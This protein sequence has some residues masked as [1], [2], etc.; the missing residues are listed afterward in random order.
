MLTVFLVVFVDLLG[1]GIVLPLAPRYARDY[2]VGWS[3]NAQ[4]LVIGAIYSSFSLMQF[5]FSPVLGRVSDRVGRRPVLF[6]S[7]L[8]SVVFY[9]L[10]AVASSLPTGQGTLALVLLL[11]SRVG[12]GIAGASVSTASAVIADCTTRQTRARGMGLIGAAFGIGFTFGPLIAYLGLE[13]FQAAHWGPGA[14][15]AGLSAAALLLA[16]L[17][18]PETRRPGGPAGAKEYFSLRRTGEVLAMPEVGRLVLVYFLVVFG[19]ATFEGTLALFTA[20]AFGLDEKDNFLVFAFVGLVL[21]V[22]Q[23]GIY[24]RFAG[25]RP[26]R[27]LMAIG[28]GAMLAGFLGLAAVGVG[29]YLLAQTG[30]SAGSLKVLFYLA[31]TVAVFGFAFVNP[32]VAALVSKSADPHR[33]GEVLGVNQSFAALG[34]IA[35]PVAGLLAFAQ[36][37]SR[38]LPYVLGLAVL[39]LVAGLIA[40]RSPQRGR[41]GAEEDPNRVRSEPDHV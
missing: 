32:S 11:A 6:L 12:A 20:D 29:G 30:G 38:A 5:V 21:M 35:G 34:R 25:K 7:L 2:M 22:V 28:V 3:E 27:Q 24:R 13:F 33:Q 31:V 17:L 15:A 9:G 36:H 10:F 19:F 23:G 41:E 37:P 8:G 18:M 26:E 16:V 39:G 14:L 4:G 1:F 40:N